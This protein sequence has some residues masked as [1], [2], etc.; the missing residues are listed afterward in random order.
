MSCRCSTRKCQL[1]TAPGPPTCSH[2]GSGFTKGRFDPI[3]L[4]CAALPPCIGNGR[5]YA[6]CYLTTDP[7][8]FQEDVDA[9]VLIERTNTERTNTEGNIRAAHLA[10]GGLGG[11]PCYCTAR[12]R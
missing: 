2:G 10:V 3:G 9:C 11:E 6:P 12:Q 4:V 7:G 8:R 5:A 1:E